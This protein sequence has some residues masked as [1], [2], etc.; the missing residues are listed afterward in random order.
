MYLGM[1]L[2]YAGVAIALQSLMAV[3][4][5]LPLFVVIDRFVVRREEAYLQRRF[6]EAY[7]KFR[8]EVRRWL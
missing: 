4:L 3:L 8:L 7:D 5:L 2:T 1:L 6:G